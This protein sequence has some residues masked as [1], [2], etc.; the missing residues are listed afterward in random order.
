M[1]LIR[2]SLYLG[3]GGVVAPNSKKQRQQK[4]VLAALQ[5][6][7]P[8]EVKR[9]GGRLRLRRFLGAASTVSG[10]QDSSGADCGPGGT[11]A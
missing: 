10:R 11:V 5:G 9:A 6:A 4:Q 1:G 8:E 3:T 2:K 7:T